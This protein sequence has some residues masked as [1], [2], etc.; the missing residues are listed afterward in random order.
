M[1]RPDLTRDIAAAG[2]GL[3]LIERLVALIRGT[4]EDR[5]RRMLAR[6]ARLNARSITASS[7]RRAAKLRARA[8]AL[9]ASASA[10]LTRTP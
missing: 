2:A 7:P 10:L 9:A 8:V 1:A 6:A 5:A 3:S 4:P